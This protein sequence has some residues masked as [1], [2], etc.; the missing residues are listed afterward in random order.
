MIGARFIPGFG[1]TSLVTVALSEVS[2]LIFL[3]LNAIGAALWVLTLGV[4]GY[5]LG[6]AMVALLGDI[7]RY[8]GPVA[9]VLLVAAVLWNGLGIMRNSFD[10]RGGSARELAI[11][12]IGCMLPYIA[13]MGSAM[14]A[15]TVGAVTSASGSARSCSA[16]RPSR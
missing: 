9:V 14:T 5:V 3:V 8:E 1:T 4:L 16:T 7:E 2:S 15:L 10:P 12:L 11:I 6:Q 13:G